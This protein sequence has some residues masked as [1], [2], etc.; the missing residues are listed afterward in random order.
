MP[1]PSRNACR[2]SPGTACGRRCCR[3]DLRQQPVGQFQVLRRVVELRVDDVVEVQIFLKLADRLRFGCLRQNTPPKGFVTHVSPNGVRVE[4]T[5][6][7]S[8]Q[9]RAAKSKPHIEASWIEPGRESPGIEAS[10]PRFRVGD[11]L[12]GTGSR[13]VRVRAGVV[14]ERD[15]ER[16]RGAAANRWKMSPG[17]PTGESGANFHPRRTLNEVCLAS[18]L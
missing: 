15:G 14:V 2:T 13:I 11:E 8:S 18:V 16:P 7:D 4:S 17:L 6:P 12:L 9:P 1:G 10:T 5:G 3:L